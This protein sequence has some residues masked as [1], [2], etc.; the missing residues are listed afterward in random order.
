MSTV[1]V[2]RIRR[3]VRRESIGVD[4]AG[5][6]NLVGAILRYLSLAFL[7]PTAIAVGY[8]ES[9]WPFLAAALATAAFGFGLERM[10]Q[11][12]ERI[13]PREGFLVVALTWAL[14]ALFVS[15]P[16]LIGEPQ[17][18]EPLDAY[19]EAMSG[20]TTTGAS[21][22]TDI[23]A[24]GH[25]MA[26]WRQLSQWLGGM[27]IIVLALAI[28]PRLRVGGRQLMEFEAPGPE[29]GETL[30]ASI[31]ET[32]RR[33][34]YL[35]VGLTV[36]MIV[37]LTVVAYSGLDDRMGFYEA[38]AHA[39]TTLPTGGFSTRARSIEEFGAASQWVIAVFM[40]LAGANFVLLYRAVVRGERRLLVRDEELR[41]Y[42]GL[43]VTATLV[44]A[45]DV[46][47]EGIH[48][49]EAAIRHAFFQS[50]SMMTTTGYASVDFAALWTPL[51]FIVLVAL[52]F[53]GGSAASTG[54]AIKVI[55]VLLLGRI[56]RRE[57]DQ[58]VHRE[59]VV[60][61][62]F[63][64]RVVDERTL[65]AVGTFVLLYVIVFALGTLVIAVDSVRAGVDVRAFD[66]VAAAATTLGNVGPGLGFAGPMGSFEPFGDISKV[67]MIVLMW[68][69]RLELLPVVVLVTKS[70]W[71]A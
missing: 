40:V 47:A 30:A 39:F 52:M 41:L 1:T 12:R 16:Y 6:L 22:L 63:N 60:P 34:W 4:V 14:G 55:R 26:M 32:A 68:M 58:T 2:A 45:Y 38:L 54:G 46:A 20:M 62:R 48:S 8:G 3:A 43:L 65:R 27:G 10:T 69:G 70:Y 28:L 42:V 5:A 23:P 66:A 67:T 17:L 50:S 24:L 21:V 25:G 31:R 37:V 56:L 57:L 18:R 11:G 9:P 71:R 15:L 51:G 33:L 44:L 29:L 64:G 53:V 13:G 7:F 59:V 49:G 36:L 19:F 35:Y 61:L